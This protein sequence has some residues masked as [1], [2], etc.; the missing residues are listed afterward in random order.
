MICVSY[1]RDEEGKKRELCGEKGKKEEE[2]RERGRES[3][4][5]ELEI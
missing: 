3:C 1:E 2:G 4:M 5:E